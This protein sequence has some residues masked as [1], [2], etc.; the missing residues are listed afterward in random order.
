MRTRKNYGNKTRE[1]KD[2][3]GNSNS[4]G[5]D[6]VAALCRVRKRLIGGL[7]K[8][9]A[10]FAAHNCHSLARGNTRMVRAV[11]LESRSV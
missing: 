9:A 2:G 6:V 4:G 3:T 7:R 8:V 1:E 5:G 10:I 11:W